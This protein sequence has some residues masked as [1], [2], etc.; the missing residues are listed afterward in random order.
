MAIVLIQVFDA[1]TTRLIQLYIVGVF[2]SFNLSQLGMIR[3]WTRHL[4]TERDPAERRRM[5]RSR[6]D[7]HL[8]PR[9]DRGRAGDRAGHQVPRRRLDHDPGDGRLLRDHAGAS[10]ATTTSVDARARRRRGGQGAADPGAR[11]RAGLQAAQADAAGAGLRQGHPAQR[12]RGASTSAIDAGATNRLLEEWDERNIDVPLKVL[13]SPY[14]E[15]V[16]PIVEYAQE[17]REGQPARRGRGLHPGVRRRA[18]GGS[19]CCTTR[20]RCGSR[21]GCSSR[22]ASWSSRCPTSCGPPRSPTSARSAT[23]RACTPATCAA[24]A[25]PTASSRSR[26]DRRPVSRRA[27]RPRKPRGASRVGERFEAEV[28]PVAHGGHCVVRLPEPEAARRLR[29]ARAARRAGGRR[30]HRGHRRRPVLA[31][32]RRRGARA[33]RRTGSAAPCPVAGPGLCGGCDFQHVA[34]ARPARRSRPPSCASSSS[35]WAACRRRPTWSPVAGRGV[36]VAGD[37]RRAALAHPPAVRRARRTVGRRMRK[38]RSHE[39]VAVD[40]CLIAAD[41]ARRPP[42]RAG[43]TAGR[44]ARRRPSARRHAAAAQSFTVA[45]DGFWQVHPGAPRVLVETVL[46]LLEPQPGE[47]ALDLYAGVGLFAASSASVGRSPRGRGR[48]RPHRVP[49]RP[50]QPG[51]AE[52]RR[53]RVRSHGPGAALRRTTSPSTSSSSTRRARAPSAPSWSRSSTAR[54]ARWRTSPATRPR[55]AATSRSSP[56]TATSSRRSG[57]SSGVCQTTRGASHSKHLSRCASD[58]LCCNC[59]RPSGARG[60]PW[61]VPSKSPKEPRTV[62][63]TA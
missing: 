54:R 10:A 35:G 55:S 29:P 60:F 9:H 41:G 40:D 37:R 28:G 39:L 51:R 8:R 32:R 22:P 33:P 59:S 62:V 36:P 42:R 34:A 61:V 21:A 6:G 12:A 17:I 23:R 43:R 18:A 24:G 25:S 57:P 49:A 52:G 44:R 38:H 63:T 31:R 1:E 3:H 48:G 5:M 11:D 14:R 58:L 45:A 53:R 7:Q 19:S 13:H 2:V 4:K 26:P 50:R 46:D 27:A 16:R 56:S 20:P 15:V 47:R 30:D